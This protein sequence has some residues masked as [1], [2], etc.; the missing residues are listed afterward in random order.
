MSRVKHNFR[1]Q[2][3]WY[4]CQQTLYLT[5]NLNCIF[6]NIVLYIRK[7]MI[8][9]QNFLSKVRSKR[10]PA[11]VM[12]TSP[13]RASIQIPLVSHV[14]EPL[15]TIV[16]NYFSAILLVIFSVFRGDTFRKDGNSF[17]QN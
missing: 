10:N 17:E 2:K 7:R 14:H 6:L 11:D 5:K 3:Q 9:I 16:V 15:L 1:K 4:S 12:E 13:P 8:H